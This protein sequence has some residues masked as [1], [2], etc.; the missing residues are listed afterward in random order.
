MY[1][2]MIIIC[3]TYNYNFYC[4]KI[5]PKTINNMVHTSSMICLKGE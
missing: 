3:H 5:G 1:E 4:T 2:L